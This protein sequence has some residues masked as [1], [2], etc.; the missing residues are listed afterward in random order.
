[1]SGS[2]K[3]TGEYIK[4]VISPFSILKS[5][6]FP[7]PKPLSEAVSLLINFVSFL[8]YFIYEPIFWQVFFSEREIYSVFLKILLF[9]A[10]NYAPY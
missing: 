3:Y 9:A 10:L 2:L 4:I 6:S 1:V 8:I 7:L 5:S